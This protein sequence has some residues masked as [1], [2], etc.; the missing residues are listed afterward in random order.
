MDAQAEDVSDPDHIIGS[1]SA[2]SRTSAA[3]VAAVA[4]GGTIVFDCGPSEVTI[5]LDETARIFNNANPD[6]VIDGG[7]W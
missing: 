5:E 1:G 4:A 7:G 6:I 3:F 2:E